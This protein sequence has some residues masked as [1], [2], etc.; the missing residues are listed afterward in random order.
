MSSISYEQL[1]ISPLLSGTTAVVAMKALGEKYKAPASG[2]WISGLFGAT[3]LASASGQFVSQVLFP[4]FGIL[5]GSAA[6]LSS[7]ALIQLGLVVLISSFV[8]YKMN[9]SLYTSLGL[10][11]VVGVI[12]IA[13]IVA[14]YVN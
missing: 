4:Y 12:A 10:G 11:M 6:S 8:L 7:G 14:Q 1:L 5:P 9:R 3:V 13:E 2:S